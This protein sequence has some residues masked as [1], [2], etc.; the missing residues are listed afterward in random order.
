MYLSYL[1]FIATVFEDKE[2]F[3]SEA[4]KLRKTNGVK[5]VIAIEKDYLFDMVPGENKQLVAVTDMCATATSAADEP[6]ALCI[7]RDMTKTQPDFQKAVINLP[8][9]MT[10]CQ[11]LQEVAKKFQYEP[12]SFELI[13]SKMGDPVHVHEHDEE[14][15]EE[16]GFRCGNNQRNNLIIDTKNS[17]PP[18]KINVNF[19]ISE[20]DDT[21]V[22]TCN[23][24]PT[25]PEIKD[26]SSYIPPPAPPPYTPGTSEFSYNYNYSNP[27]PR[28]ET[29]FVGLVNQAMT[30]YLNSLLQ[31]L[32]M[33]PEFRNALYRWEF[34][35][36]E[37]E[38]TKSIPFQ[39]QKLFLQLQTSKKP[40]VGTTELTTSFGWDSSEAWQQHDIQ[41]LCRVMFDA[42]EQKFKNTEQS[43]LI[44][45][46]YEGKMKDYVKCLECG[47]ES[48]REV[49]F[50]D[51]PLDVRPFGSSQAYKSV[52]IKLNDRKN[53]VMAIQLLWM[54]KGTAPLKQLVLP[55]SVSEDDLADDDEG[56]DVD[57]QGHSSEQLE[58]NCALM[59]RI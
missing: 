43:D 20:Y 22:S 35:G 19:Q 25:V 59:R 23:E 32:F 34:D 14:T 54:K 41:E 9:S 48:A 24:E 1:I 29:G 8:A 57:S 51:V 28:Q 26:N 15:L 39:L 50:L 11:L 16:L 3:K 2:V 36:T 13:Y 53:Q 12:D 5:I 10:A 30:C 56:I 49:V 27:L 42:L 40:A 38:G 17:K 7:I 46:L 47:Y 52:R 58:G 31:T 18:K 55:S 6:R 45:R 4:H 21:S 44:S 33:T 37:D